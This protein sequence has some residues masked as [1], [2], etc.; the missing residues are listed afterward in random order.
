MSLN[1]LRFGGQY[2]GTKR[3][4]TWALNLFAIFVFLPIALAFVAGGW[5]GI[6][7]RYV[8]RLVTRPVLGGE[9]K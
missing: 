3:P 5:C 1:G 6:F 2:I 4:S 7:A 9:A 8:T